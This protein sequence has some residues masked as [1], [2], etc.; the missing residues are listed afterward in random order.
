V[1]APT[2]AAVV[3]VMLRH[4]GMRLPPRLVATLE[5]ES[6]LNDPMAVFL[7]MLL[8]EAL[9]APAE[10]SPGHAGLAFLREMGGGLM[11]GVA[12]GAAIA[13][14]LRRLQPGPGLAPALCL[15]GAFTVF[16]GAQIAETSGF[17][18]LYVAGII[19]G[20]EVARDTGPAAE[21]MLP[22]FEAL[23]WLAQ[24]SLFLMLGLLVTPHDIDVLPNLALGMVLIFIARP[25]SCLPCLLPLG[26]GLRQSLFASW[27]GLRGAVPVYLATIPLLLGVPH[28]EALFNAAF[29]IVITSLVIQGWTIGPVA[30]LLKVTE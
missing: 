20:R 29:V 4:S 17:L 23:G 27:V 1:V 6:G 16:G 30:K 8:V 7:T 13:W 12:G 24:I 15:A 21:V 19:V 3:T 28:S 10:F 22:F 5:V 14:L 25:L 2:D 9:L 18:A 26:F 11:L